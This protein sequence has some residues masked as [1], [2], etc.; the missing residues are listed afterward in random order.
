MNIPSEEDF[1]A[2]NR[3][4]MS[5]RQLNSLLE[6]YGEMLKGSEALG[7]RFSLATNTLRLEHDALARVR[8]ARDH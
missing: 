3:G 7:E 1:A 2:W 4:T 5:E 8:W 6:F